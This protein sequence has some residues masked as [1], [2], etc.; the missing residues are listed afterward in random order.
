V[1]KSVELD[2]SEETDDTHLR[3][4]AR[5]LGAARKNGWYHRGRRL[6]NCVPTVTAGLR[7]RVP[8]HSKEDLEKSTWPARRYHTRE[9]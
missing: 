5:A 8:S 2:E 3:F 1:E 4:E 9:S 6:D 7:E